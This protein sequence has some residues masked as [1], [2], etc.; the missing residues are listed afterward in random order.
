MTSFL[1]H[2]IIAERNARKT[3]CG[4]LGQA[5]SSRLHHPITPQGNVVGI[6]IRSTE[7]TPWSRKG[8]ESGH[9]CTS[10]PS[11]VCTLQDQCGVIVV[12]KPEGVLVALNRIESG[13]VCLVKQPVVSHC[14]KQPVGSDRT[15]SC[16][17]QDDSRR[18]SLGMIPSFIHHSSAP[19]LQRKGSSSRR[20]KSSCLPFRSSPKQARSQSCTRRSA[21][22]SRS[23]SSAL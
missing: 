10:S 23:Q 18:A 13:Q 12:I 19:N 22:T 14:P 21:S 6:L 7:S 9:V 8:G 15:H 2:I 17:T 5:Y 11:P 1:F 4:E 16:Q 3:E 20:R